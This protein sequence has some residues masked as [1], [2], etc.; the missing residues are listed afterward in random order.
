MP[1]NL[2]FA[3]TAKKMLRRVCQG[4][5]AVVRDTKANKGAVENMLV[6]CEFLDVFFKDYQ[7]CYRKEI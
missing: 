6:V 4:Y 5:L 3:I 2:I 1:Q 7:G